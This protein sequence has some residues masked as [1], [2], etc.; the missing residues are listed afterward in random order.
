MLTD[1]VSKLMPPG[2]PCQPGIPGQKAVDMVSGPGSSGIRR[3][4]SAWYS[5]GVVHIA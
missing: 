4:K 1:L 2:E 3:V 5:K